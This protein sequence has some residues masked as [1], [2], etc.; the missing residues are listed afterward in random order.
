MK[1]VKIGLVC[2]MAAL[3]LCACGQSVAHTA[4]ETLDPNIAASASG[5]PYTPGSYSDTQQGY[6]GG[7]TVTMTFCE[8]AITA[9]EIS[10]ESE[11]RDVGTKAMDELAPAILAGQSAEVDAVAS[12]TIT[13]DAIKA[14]V[15]S[16]IKQARA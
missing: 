7:I 4:S 3:F 11:T 15:Q 1:K 14:A 10:G 16:C 2:L 8:S 12:A 5:G 13:S 6:G 9:I